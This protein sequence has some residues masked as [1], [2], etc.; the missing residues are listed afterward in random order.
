MPLLVSILNGESPSCKLSQEATLNL[1]TAFDTRL[2]QLLLYFDMLLSFR[3]L[4]TLKK[5]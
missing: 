4:H 1:N 3:F 2:R 5:G